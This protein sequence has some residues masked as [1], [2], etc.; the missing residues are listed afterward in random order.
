VPWKG[1]G[2]KTKWGCALPKRMGKALLF[3]KKSKWWT[4]STWMAV[5]LDSWLTLGWMPDAIPIHLLC[6]NSRLLVASP[7][8]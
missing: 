8:E 3:Y 1:K 7:S 4:M 5:V 6:I 2:E